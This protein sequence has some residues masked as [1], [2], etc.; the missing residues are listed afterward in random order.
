M[1]ANTEGNTMLKVLCLEDS[2]QDVEI[3]RE[4]LVGAGYD[5]KMDC[6]AVEKEFVSFLRSSTYDIIL[7]DFK[8]PGFD[9]FTALR[10]AMEICPNVPFIC[11]SGTIGEEKAIELLKQ[12]AFDY[13]IKDRL[14]RLPAA[15][16]R[17]LDEVK[18]KEI[19]RRTEKE[20]LSEQIMLAR[21]ESVAHVGSW[22]W[23]IA[24]DTVIW[25][26]ELFQIFQRDPQEGA[27]S[28]AEHPAFYHPDDMARLQIAV[29][30]AV[31][32]GTPY[33][34]E[35]RAIRKD[36]E[37]RVCVARGVT[38][39]DPGGRVVRLF[40]SLQD[41]TERKQSEVALRE[42]EEKYR[43]FFE[44]SMDA[45]L[46][47]TP[48]GKIL[49]A[50]HAACEMFGYLEEE[51]IKLGRSGIMDITDP[52]LSA[53]LS[54]RELK[55]KA[56][57]ELTLIR[58]DGTRFPS[59]ISSANF[60]SRE[61]QESASI[62]IHDI[63][64]RK[65][66]E[67]ALRQSEEKF[68]CLFESSW[69]AIMIMEPPS[70]NFTTG[71]PATVKMFEAKNE[72]EFVSHGPWELSPDRQPDGRASA[73]K[74]KEMIEAAMREGSHFFEWT[75]RRIGGKEF[76]ADV[77]LTRMER[78]GKMILQAT[79]RDITERKLV[80]EKVHKQEETLRLA[81]DATADGIWDWDIQTNKE[82]FSP[83]WC[84]IIGYSIDDP[85]FLHTYDSW[86]SRIHPEDKDYVI[87]SL[88][89][90]LEKG[91]TYDVE[92][93]HLHK[94]G[95]Y[96]W[97]KSLGK[98]IRNESNKP[99]RMVGCIRDITERK[100]AEEKLSESEV[101]YRSI[102]Q[103][104][105]DAIVTAD[106]NGIIIGWNSGAER[107]FGYSYTEAAGQSLT[108]LMPLFH[109][110]GHTIGMKRVQS[111]GDQHVIG[112]TVELEGLRKDN[113][114]FPIELSLSI[115][116]TKAGHFFTGIIRDITERKQAEES[117]RESED[118]FRTLYENATIGLYR[119]AP[120]GTILLANKKL[121]KMLGYTSFQQ[122]A[123]RNLEKDGFESSSQR[124]EFLEKIERDGE[125]NGHDAKW[126]LQN[127][128][129]IFVLESARAIRD[130]QGKTMYYDGT[131]EDNTER[132]Q[133][134]EGLRQMQKLEGLGTLAGGIAHD[135]NNILGIILAYITS[136]KRFK[137]DTK[138]LDLAVDT[139]VKAVERGKTL[140]QQILT[141]ARKTETA[142]G[143]VDVND[144]VMEIMTMIMETFPQ[145]LTYG[146]N[147]DKA[148]PYINADRSQLYQVLLNLCVNARDAMP[149]GGVLIINTCIVSS[150]R[151]CNRHPE[152]VASSYVCIEV[153][154]TGE[155]MTEET[156]KRIF[157][158][159]FTTK[160]I[161][162]GTGL[163]LAVV[164]GI[165]KIHKGFIDVESELGNLPAGKAGGTTFRV[166]LPASRAAEPISVKDEETLEEIPG[167]TE[168]LL[169]VEDE[170]MLMMSLRMVLVEK[171]YKVLSTGD[172]LAGVNMYKE[173]KKEIAVVLTDLGLPKMNGMEVCAHIK[174][175]NPSAR[176]IVA[177]G[178]L[179][180]EMKE[181]FLKA[182]I[183][184][185]LLKPYDLKQVLKVIR[186]VLDGK[187]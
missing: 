100:R 93:R 86:A 50:N 164:F 28:F 143:A 10:W 186:A 52:R 81:V 67:E 53:F 95:E 68:R 108:S 48:D 32:D 70:W 89:N 62:I 59:E 44:N 41:I 35:L 171:G 18:E 118:R 84:E 131:V 125:V 136:T 97:Q 23:D 33:V 178:Y 14:A 73:E 104:A 45:I 133:M 160:E 146:Q 27:P 55:G 5:L 142:F 156:Q 141:F 123:E 17:A 64:T 58:K 38:E 155:G 163:G 135:F 29:E 114:V 153:I 113:S 127:G 30:A 42:S 102:L 148:V 137:D 21:T 162:K 74:S 157:E 15:M 90:H 101:K 144:V 183:Q 177:T 43:S 124:K 115:W 119:T 110:D 145:N 167:G 4:L 122:L 7:S 39:M 182:G 19:R 47:A 63:T 76:P 9:G 129:A 98:A 165:V 158:P 132:R 75:H 1:Q 6:T 94:S 54:E 126:I 99:V 34:L 80:E 159:F 13:I 16:K 88:T 187:S 36:G 139:I 31:N 96:R 176:L 154:D 170:E 51:L 184:N 40:G 12:G 172:G 152:A 91:F 61:D 147:Y 56:R 103:S 112:K 168:T 11:I 116:E 77:L 22:E 24:T 105:T 181:E 134:E 161:G 180:P 60:K 111:G 175:I 179:D 46:L 65:H 128:N 69:D 120:D 78:N 82:F 49:S 166:Y 109:R 130:A 117:L 173:R 174:K 85:E 83:R 8:L 106:N 26:D 150:I 37:T 87:T 2:P 151:L 71:N 66:A 185:F 121:V 20:L 149:K 140:V 169:V 57:S 3:M 138:K 107:I 72:E 79:V 25:S 92:F